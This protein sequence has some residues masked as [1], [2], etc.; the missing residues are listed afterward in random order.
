MVKRFYD[1]LEDA[2]A[3]TGWSLQRACAEA[4]VSYDQFK[5]FK[6]R[7]AKDPHASTNV[8]DAVKIANAFGLTLDEFLGD[9]TAELR[10]EAAD[11]WRKLGEAE[12]EILLAAARGQRG[13]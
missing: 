12:R 3:A 2:L 6:Q 1:A 13:G 11:L 4:G 10:S 5:K 7:A 9:R 8:D